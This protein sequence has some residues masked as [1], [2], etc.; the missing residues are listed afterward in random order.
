MQISY[1]IILDTLQDLSPIKGKDFDGSQQF[2]S[3]M[4]L[5]V[6]GSG[7]KPLYIGKLS[8]WNGQPT[9]SCLLLADGSPVPDEL[10]GNVVVSGD[11]TVEELARKLSEFFVKINEWYEK[12]LLA[13]ATN[14]SIQEILTLSE[15]IIG[16]FISVSDSSLSLVGYTKN[17]IP[18][19]P[20]IKSLIANGYHSDE[21]Y[22]LFKASNRF[23]LWLNTDGL[24]VQ[25]DHK[26]GI[27]DL[28]SK[29]FKYDR[30]YFMHAVMSCNNKPITPGLLELFGI[31]CDVLE[32]IVRSSWDNE[33][34]FSH[35]YNSLVINL[36]NRTEI[37][38]RQAIERRAEVI[39][40]DPS[41]EYVIIVAE[42]ESIKSGK[43]FPGRIAQDIFS[44]FPRMHIVQYEDD[45]LLLLHYKNMAQYIEAADMVAKLEEYFGANNMIGGMSDIFSD[46]LELNYAYEQAKR[47]LGSDFR[48]STITQFE[49]VAAKC[50]VNT[51]SESQRLWSKS[52]CGKFLLDLY[53]T[54]KEKQQ[55]NLPLLYTYLKNE[56]RARE[57]ADEVH[58]H[59]N[60]VVYRINRI[61]EA[62]GINLDDPRLRLNILL[63]FVIFEQWLKS[64]N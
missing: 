21:A 64:Q 20:I 15:P 61:E 54:D 6:S 17:I 11:T 41:D 10:G 29:V 26:I 4:P 1:N 43:A 57:T 23:E 8:E 24:I 31:M 50:L 47:A 27:F 14:K 52:R 56:R 9:S 40:V 55:N 34:F 44:M 49:R 28:V 7:I 51:S 5:T 25:T 36:I 32:N 3:L 30:T 42:P 13:V 63:S 46:I 37:A 58:M 33:K 48:E 45:L 2:L 22:K 12:T 35:T 39:G 18:D 59:R 19:D 38:D 16:N 60:N 62:Y 53:R